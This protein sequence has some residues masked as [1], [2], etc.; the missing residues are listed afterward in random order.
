[1]FMTLEPKQ[2][3]QNSQVH[4]GYIAQDVERTIFKYLSST[5]KYNSIR[6]LNEDAKRYAILY[7]DET[8]LSLLYGEIQVIKDAYY[9]RKIEQLE[10]DIIELKRKPKVSKGFRR[11][12]G[13]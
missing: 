3:V 2:Y 7:K 1:M 13:K 9:K 5:N 4:F 10:Y 12:K 11:K 6:E 8:F